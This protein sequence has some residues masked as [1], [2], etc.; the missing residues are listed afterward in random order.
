MESDYFWKMIWSV[1]WVVVVVFGAVYAAWRKVKEKRKLNDLA[2]YAIVE[3]QKRKGKTGEKESV[4][5]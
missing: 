2:M 3:A 4:D 1:F 5:N